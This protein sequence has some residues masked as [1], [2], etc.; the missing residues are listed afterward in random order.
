MPMK[1][2]KI[3]VRMC[4]GCQERKEKK[5]L[6]RIVKSPEGKISLDLTGKKSGRGVYICHDPKCLAQAKKTKRLERAF[7]CAIP[8]EVYALLEEEIQTGEG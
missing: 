3:P 1:A 6:V 4:V 5:A 2:K 7:S 8:N